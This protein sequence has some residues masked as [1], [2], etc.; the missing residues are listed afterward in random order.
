MDAMGITYEA[1]P[2]QRWTDPARQDPFYE[3]TPGKDGEPWEKMEE[4][5]AGMKQMVS[6]P[7]SLPFSIFSGTSY[8]RK[9]EKPATFSK[10]TLLI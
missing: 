9:K 10:Y 6:A 5:G 8:K 1:Y 2:L 7:D 4:L 3:M